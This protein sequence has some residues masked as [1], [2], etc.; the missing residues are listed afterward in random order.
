M[1]ILNCTSTLDPFASGA[2]GETLFT[3]M[4]LLKPP[5]FG[6]EG[7]CSRVLPW[8]SVLPPPDRETLTAV[9]VLGRRSAV[10]AGA[11]N[12][13]SVMTRKRSRERFPP[14]LLVNRRRIESVPNVALFGGSLVKSRATFGKAVSACNGSIA[15]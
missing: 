13:L 9:E 11:G 15:E 8:T 14:V 10:P 12:V 6:C 4:L 1:P 5:P 2:P 3:P 7:G